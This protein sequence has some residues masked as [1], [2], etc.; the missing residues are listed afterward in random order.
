MA[1]FHALS[2]AAS[3]REKDTAIVEERGTHAR[4][5][6]QTDRQTDRQ[7]HSRAH[8]QWYSP[9][10]ITSNASASVLGLLPPHP[11]PSLRPPVCLSLF[12]GDAGSIFSAARAGSEA[13]TCTMAIALAVSRCLCPPLSVSLC[14]Q[15]TSSAQ[16]A[17]EYPAAAPYPWGLQG[18]SLRCHLLNENLQGGRSGRQRHRQIYR[19]LAHVE[20]IPRVV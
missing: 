11:S 12:A 16:R 1:D 6:R 5:H 17:L 18:T 15:K 9:S 3:E 8:G 4:T 10:T 13:T 20:G 7:R 19:S 14:S 2:A